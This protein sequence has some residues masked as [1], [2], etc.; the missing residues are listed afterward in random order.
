MAEFLFFF[1]LVSMP[2]LM[3]WMIAASRKA[4][5]QVSELE[6]TDEEGPSYSRFAFS[7]EEIGPD[8]LS[9]GR[10]YDGDDAVIPPDH[11]GGEL[12]G[13]KSL[14]GRR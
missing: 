1:G 2:L 8:G 3:W 6:E 11:S 4:R 7:E 10:R 9:Y 13:I 12:P 14:Q 5:A